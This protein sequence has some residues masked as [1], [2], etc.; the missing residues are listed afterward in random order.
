MIAVDLHEQRSLWRYVGLIPFYL[1]MLYGLWLSAFGSQTR[2][3]RRGVTLLWLFIFVYSG[4][5]LLSWSLIR[6]RLPVDAVLVIFAG[7]AVADLG[8][9]LGISSRARSRLP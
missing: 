3:F 9:R 4:I 1:L 6:Y 2:G 5:H 8:E 7:L